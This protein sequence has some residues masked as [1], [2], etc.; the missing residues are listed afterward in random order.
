MTTYGQ[1]QIE[2]LLSRYQ[3]VVLGT[4]GQAGPQAGRV[5]AEMNDGQIILKIDRTSDHL[6]NLECK[7]DLVILTP[8]WELHGTGQILTA[9]AVVFLHPWQAAIRVTPTRLHILDR[10]SGR[11]LE[12]VDFPTRAA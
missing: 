7:P 8:A 6:F 5:G 4:C 12:T 11:R 1:T 2:D 3:V 10:E 9:G